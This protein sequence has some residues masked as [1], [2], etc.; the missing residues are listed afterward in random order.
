MQRNALVTAVA[1][2]LGAVPFAAYAQDA[3]VPDDFGSISA[4]VANAADAD[5]DGIVQI[6]VRAGVYQETFTIARD[7]L[8]LT[9]EDRDT[10][11]IQGSGS[12]DTIRV[13]ADGVTISGFTVTSAGTF[14]GIDIN[15]TALVTVEGN[16][17][18]GGA[19]GVSVDR[20]QVVVVADNE[21]FGTSREAIN[22]DRCSRVIV[23]GNF[24]HDNQDEGVTIDGCTRSRVQSNVVTDNGGNGIRDRGSSLNVHVGN[25]ALRNGDEG[26]ILEDSQRVRIVG[27]TASGNRENGIRMRNTR[28]TLVSANAFTDNGSYGVRR[29]D[30]FNDDFDG[31]QPGVQNPPGKNDL[32]GNDDG[33]LRED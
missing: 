20:S 18:T 9:G 31:S 16:V 24:V 29:E 1:A 19:S 12:I 7:N 4:A 8:E 3:I 13:R 15:R 10:T 5:G 22:L 21:V 26:Y 14:D 25:Q 33:P 32:S 28:N 23:V 30:W 2:V 17:L 11:V 27:N 6:F